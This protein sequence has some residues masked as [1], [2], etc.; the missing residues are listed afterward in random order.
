MW[1]LPEQINILLAIRGN[2]ACGFVIKISQTIICF[3]FSSA[4]LSLAPDKQTLGSFSRAEYIREF[5]LLHPMPSAS[6]AFNI[7]RL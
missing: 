7:N 4:D 2:P 1:L 6:T 5:L 3:Y